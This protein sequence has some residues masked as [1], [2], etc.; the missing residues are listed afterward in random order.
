LKNVCD[1]FIRHPDRTPEA[2]A[3]DFLGTPWTRNKN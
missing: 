1:P 2:I 3:D